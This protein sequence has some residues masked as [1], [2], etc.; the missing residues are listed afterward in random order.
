VFFGLLVLT[1]LKYV[2]LWARWILPYH[3]VLY[4][5]QGF[6]LYYNEF[7]INN[8]LLQWI[9]YGQYGVHATDLFQTGLS[10]ARIF[11]GFFGLIF[12]VTDTL[13]LFNISLFTEECILLIG[14]YLLAKKNFRFQT[15][16]FF[17]CVTVIL[18][19]INIRTNYVGFQLY[20]S[21]PIILYFIQKFF[22]NAK[23]SYILTAMNIFVLS[24]LGTTGYSIAVQFLPINIFV[25]IFFCTRIKDWR[26]FVSITRNDF[27]V[28]LVLFMGFL[29]FMSAYAVHLLDIKNNMELL[30]SGRDAETFGNSLNTFLS[31]ARFPNHLDFFDLFTPVLY[32][33]DYAIYTGL[34]TLCFLIFSFVGRRPPVYW[35]S[36]ITLIILVLFSLGDRTPIAGFFYYYYPVMKY[37]RHVGYVIIFWII[38]APILAGFGL[39]YWIGK[40][41]QKES[42]F[43]KL[44]VVAL[45]AVALFDLTHY[46]YLIFEHALKAKQ[47]SA[48]VHDHV[49]R[50]YDYG[51][52]PMRTESPKNQRAHDSRF[53]GTYPVSTHYVISYQMADWDPCSPQVLKVDYLNPY[54]AQ[55]L[56][57]QGAAISAQ[58]FVLPENKALMSSLGCGQSKIKILRNPS[59][60]ESEIVPK[61]LRVT[62]YSANHIRIQADI[63]DTLPVW[64]YYADAW[65]PAWQA[66]VNSRPQ[67]IL[68]MNHAFKGV[69]LTS[70]VNDIIFKYDNKPV[71]IAEYILMIYSIVWGGFFLGLFGR[72]LF[73][74][75]G[76][77][78]STV[79]LDMENENN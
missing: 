58:E 17:V 7:F 5:Y 44:A 6:Y 21:L 74:S 12:R 33:M 35:M 26:R 48:P 41:P 59:S 42:K 39:D 50:P 57:R 15:T 55:Y 1:I 70:L 73:F 16:V 65:H 66:L 56:R 67:S 43:V 25:I 9:P 40:F 14:I 22:D 37:Y 38:F 34:L 68:Q 69:K 77:S 62:E 52:Q 53:I 23:F 8:Q 28:S 54:V 32:V 78:E 2:P 27:L 29:I 60:L 36:L 64:L 4:A 51:Y 46:R 71:R 76:N 20:Y 3:D 13:L 79:L 45:I 47:F 72:C 30:S 11:V 10:P 19:S 18:S 24:L 31:Y 61:Q 49:F 63:R 75:F